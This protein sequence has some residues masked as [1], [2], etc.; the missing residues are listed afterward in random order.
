MSILREFAIATTSP[1][2][3]AHRTMVSLVVS[4]A[5]SLL[6]A[7]CMSQPTRL[8]LRTAPDPNACP[9]AALPLPLQFRIDPSA[10]E[11]ILAIASDKQPYHVV[12]APGFKAGA[13]TPP[14]VLDP[15]GV[16]VARDGEVLS[17]PLLHGYTVCATSDS[18][19]VLLV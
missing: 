10:R 6:L 12:W 2:K 8:T 14:T 3:W 5:L 15:N 4:V 1:R 16:V 13:G 7:S 11:Q 17:G 19:Y 18:I 9:G